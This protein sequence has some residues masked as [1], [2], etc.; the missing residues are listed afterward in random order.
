ME[1]ADRTVGEMS[2]RNKIMHNIKSSRAY[3]KKER[4]KRIGKH[5][6]ETLPRKADMADVDPGIDYGIS[7]SHSIEVTND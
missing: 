5:P 4:L 3:G 2:K 1:L 7:K 6:M